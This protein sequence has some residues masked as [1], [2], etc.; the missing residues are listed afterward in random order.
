M[1]PLMDMRKEYQD[2][3]VAKHGIKLGFM[4]AFIKASCAAA[5][6][7][8]A[9]NGT[10]EDNEIVMR[11]YV[12]VSVAVSTPTGLVVPVLRNA[13]SMSFA[14]VE[15]GLA[16]LALK[17]REGKITLEDMAGG[18]F[19]ISNGGVYGSLMGTPILNPPQSAI[20]GM[21]GIKNRP[22][23]IGDKIEARPMMYLALTYDHR[24]IDGRE[25]VL[26]LRK[27]KESIEDPRTLLLDL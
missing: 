20:L 14:E 9:V 11:D 17:A 25:A 18:T 21:H 26:F 22:V 10:I 8:P 1:K 4:S 24:L 5:A 13:E 6:A 16:D 23:C 7:Q 12:D 19:T 3:F 27:I 2:Q 15:Q